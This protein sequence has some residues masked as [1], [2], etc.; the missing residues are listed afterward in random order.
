MLSRYAPPQGD[1]ASRRAIRHRRAGVKIQ[2][3]CRVGTSGAAR[4]DSPTR[5]RRLAT[6]ATPLVSLTEAVSARASDGCFAV[7]ARPRRTIATNRDDAHRR[8]RSSALARVAK[9]SSGGAGSRNNSERGPRYRRN[10]CPGSS[11]ARDVQRRLGSG[12]PTP[13][14]Q[15]AATR[16]LPGRGRATTRWSRLPTPAASPWPSSATQRPLHHRPCAR[17]TRA[18]RRAKRASTRVREPRSRPRL[19]PR[20]AEQAEARAEQADEE[21]GGPED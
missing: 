12:V 3:W 7:P 16:A 5:A 14:V 13:P 17:R 10:A 8:S 4:S 19:A 21:L 9:R 18:D 6:T 15:A 1:L 2:R 11:A 20:A